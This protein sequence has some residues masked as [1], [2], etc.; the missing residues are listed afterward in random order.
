MF[1]IQKKTLLVA[2]LLCAGACASDPESQTDPSQTTAG[3]PGA[4]GSPG[5]AG[6]TPGAAGSVAAVGGSSA[7]PAG[8]G[9]AGTG[10]QAGASAGGAPAAGSAASAA[11]AG[12][13]TAGTSSSATASGGYFM[14]GRWHGYAWTST[15]GAGSTVM[16]MDFA[17]LAAGAPLCVSGSV[18]AVADYSGVAMLGVNLNQE[19]AGMMPPAM[20]VTPMGA[21]LVVNVMNKGN[22]PLRVQIQGANGAMDANDRW[23]APLT[24]TGGLIPWTSFNTACW[25]NSGTAYA[26]QPIVAAMVVVPGGTSAAV[27]YDFCLVSLAEGDMGAA[28]GSGAAGMGAAGMGAA[29]GGGAAGTPG[30]GA[31][32]M[33][34]AGSPAAS[35]GAMLN[36]G[37]NGG[38][39]MISDRTGN[40][41]VTR[42]GRNYVVQNNVWGSS[43]SQTLTYNGPTFEVTSQSG[44]N[45]TGGAPVSYPSAFI[46]SNYNRT[47]SGSNLPKQVSALGT[48]QT[49][50]SHNAAGSIAG[51][52]NASYDVWFSTGAAGDPAAPSG[53][54]LM[55]WLVDPANA[56]PIG[57][58]VQNGASVGGIPGNWDV[59]LGTND[60][61][62]CISYV[63][64]QRT[65][66]MEF[67]LNAFIKDAVKRPNAIQSSWYLSNV[68]AGFEIWSGGVGLKSTAFY[69]IVS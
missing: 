33:A 62:P 46:G 19:Q 55:V 48:V 65:D 69:A 34:A 24:G 45:G 10:A 1:V 22:S 39:G 15:A 66:S 58:V 61:K 42:D 25:D 26:N 37:M 53:G 12:A 41:P 2:A 49:G 17:M 51:T 8:R 11:G 63:R 30:A 35:G 59:W 21:G 6:A 43:A 29:A 36:G 9:A 23:C 52:Y 64:T 4:A 7:A 16:P 56:Q 27:P 47:T 20:T 5:A 54:Y 13:G 31:A 3:T 68:F 18:A 32:G 67:D 38:S 57:G 44:S 40:A 14:S 28:A 50:W 60:G